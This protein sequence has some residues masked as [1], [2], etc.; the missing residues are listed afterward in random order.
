M[1]EI[2]TFIDAAHYAI[3]NGGYILVCEGN[4]K[5]EDYQKEPVF[6]RIENLK[7]LENIA[8]NSEYIKK[9]FDSISWLF[10]DKDYKCFAKYNST[11]HVLKVDKNEQNIN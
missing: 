3:S 4:P 9:I 1:K 7:Q 2:K 5:K 10:V 8:E 6:I 11:T